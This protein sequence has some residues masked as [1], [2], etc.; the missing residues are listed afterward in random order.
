MK[1]ILIVGLLL[2]MILSTAAPS[3]AQSSAVASVNT[4]ALNVRTGP[5]MGYGAIVSLPFGFGVEMVGRNVQGNWILIKLTN[6][7]TGW[8]NLSYLFTQY[9]TRSLPVTEAPVAPTVAPTGTTAGAYAGNIRTGAGPNDPII[10]TVPL[11]TPVVLL[12]RN[13]NGTWAKVRLNNGTEGWIETWA[14]V[15]TVPVRS[16]SP[17]DG[18]VFVPGAPSVPTSPGGGTGSL[19]NYVVQRGD[20]L[21][22]I[23]QRFGVSVY[24]IAQANGIYNTNLIYA[25]QTLVIP[26]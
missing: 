8:V 13:Y 12:G 7:V 23:A 6:G 26:A 20:T 3:F 9:P 25:G 19:Q 5:G 14:L 15:T 17:A 11:N 22:A 18:S 4:G 16:L 1:R 2:V 21:W 24:A 10:V